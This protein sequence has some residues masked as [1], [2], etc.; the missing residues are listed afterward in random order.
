[1]KEGYI[2]LSQK[3]LKKLKVMNAYIDGT[4]DRRRAAELLSLSERQISRLKKGLIIQ[5]ETFLIHKNSN[6]KP[7]HAVSKEV[8]E[9]ILKIHSLPEYESVNFLHFKDIL[10]D[11]HH[12]KLSYTALSSILKSSGIKSLNLKNLN[13]VK[14]EGSAGTAQENCCKS[15]QRH[16]T[17]L[18][19]GRCYLSTEL[20]M[21]LLEQL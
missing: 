4:I 7:S 18:G 5:G 14:T 1:M 21:M 12:I 16:L 19:M 8:K 20:L 15:M 11:K 9:K 10:A 13:V 6:R 3:Q 17:G 2:T